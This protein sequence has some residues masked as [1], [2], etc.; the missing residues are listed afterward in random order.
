MIQALSSSMISPAS[1]KIDRASVT[2]LE[3]RGYQQ[4]MPASNQDVSEEKEGRP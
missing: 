2:E 3:C 4:T 1:H